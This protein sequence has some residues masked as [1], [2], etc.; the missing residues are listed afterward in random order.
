MPNLGPFVVSGLATGAV[1]AL[2]AVA[3]VILFRASGVV[4]LAQGAIGALS[5]IIAWQIGHSG[6]PPWI[7]WIAGVVAAVAVSLGYGRLL[8]PRVADS[9]PVVRAVATL[10]LGLVLLGVMDFFL[11]RIWPRSA[12]A[13]R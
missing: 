2:S 13:D 10:G 3:I 9:D 11:G 8:A 12:P 4:N 7:G 1:Y 6:G 5:A